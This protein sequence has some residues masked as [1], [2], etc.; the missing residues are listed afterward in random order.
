[1][2]VKI[3]PYVGAGEFFY[4]PPVPS[5]S[6]ASGAAASSETRPLLGHADELA[7]AQRQWLQRR[8]H[9]RAAA[10]TTTNDEPIDEPSSA[11][12]ALLSDVSVQGDFSHETDSFLSSFC[13]LT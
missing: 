6:T 7:D 4:K 3:I 12:S 2:I 10:T 9:R 8:Q 1:M 13:G 5:D 11:H